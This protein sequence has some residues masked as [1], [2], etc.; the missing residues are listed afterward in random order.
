[1]WLIDQ[2]CARLYGDLDTLLDCP[3]FV[4]VNEYIPYQNV[5]DNAKPAEATLALE[6]MVWSADVLPYPQLFIIGGRFDEK[7]H[8]DGSALSDERRA[9]FLTAGKIFDARNE[10]D[11]RLD[12]AE[13]YVEEI[14][15]APQRVIRLTPEW[16]RVRIA[17]QE[18][19]VRLA[20]DL[21]RLTVAAKGYANRLA[22]TLEL[23]LDLQL[24]LD[25]EPYGD[26]LEK[27]ELNVEFWDILTDKW[28][29]LQSS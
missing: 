15:F 11:E 16:L 14:D 7:P 5:M 9:F 22:T 17:E 24:S 20:R 4:L 10:L 2:P 21:L 25:I 26:L 6:S 1:M 3:F 12:E 18:A 23:Q 29:D 28:R 19:I 27:I 8:L 13:R